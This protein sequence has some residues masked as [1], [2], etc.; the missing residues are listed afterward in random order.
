MSQDIKA[1]T[2]LWYL[3]LAEPIGLRLQA[4]PLEVV[5]AKLYVA[6][7]KTKDPV[8]IDLQVRVSTSPAGNL[9]ICHRRPR[10]KTGVAA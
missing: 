7:A 2:D 9:I 10:A 3:A 8:L 4:E 5:R 6:R 1:L